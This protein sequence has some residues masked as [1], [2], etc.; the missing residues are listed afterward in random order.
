LML[1]GK[2]AVF[3]SFVVNSFDFKLFI[4]QAPHC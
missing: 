4:G 1:Q 2:F 3:R